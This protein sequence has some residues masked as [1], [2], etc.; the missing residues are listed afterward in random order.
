MVLKFQISQN[1]V[2]V[3]FTHIMCPHSLNN[4]R[5]ELILL[6]SKEISYYLMNFNSLQ[7]LYKLNTFFSIER[8][9]LR[10]LVTIIIVFILLTFSVLEAF[11]ILNIC[12]SQHLS[13]HFLSEVIHYIIRHTQALNKF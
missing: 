11:V 8:C 3:A 5:Y 12:I 2:I 9:P 13:E 6:N 10:N 7:L 1:C 4:Y